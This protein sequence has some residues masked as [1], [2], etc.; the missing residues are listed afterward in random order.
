MLRLPMVMAASALCALAGP[1]R[2]ADCTPDRADR[3]FAHPYGEP[4]APCPETRS[5]VDR[6]PVLADDRAEPAH[7]FRSM[8]IGGMSTGVSIAGLGGMTLLSGYLMTDGSK[9]QKVTNAIGL[10]LAIT[11][12]ALFLAGAV[13]L[14]VDAAAAP[15]PTPDAKGAQLTFAFRW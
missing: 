9:S 15:A 5:E 3:A 13:L 6:A 10:T 11:G 7:R 2:A 1:A 14:G 4:T 12:G 8:A